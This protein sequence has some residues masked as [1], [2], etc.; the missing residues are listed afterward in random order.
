[1]KTMR[2]LL[3]SIRPHFRPL[4]A[5][6]G[7]VLLV[8][9]PSLLQ[10]GALGHPFSDMPDHYWGSWFF[11]EELLSGRW[12]IHSKIT[13][14]PEGGT[15]WIV[16]PVGGLLML[17]LRPLGFPGAWNTG[18]FLQ[19]LAACWAGYWFGWTQLKAQKPAFLVGLACGLSP[20]ALGI[21]HSGLSEYVG[22][23]WPPLFIGSLFLAYAKKEGGAWPGFLLF[24]ASLQALTFGLFGWLLALCF[25]PGPGFRSR[26]GVFFKLSGVWAALTLPLAL[27]IRSTLNASDALIHKANA[28]AWNP[29]TLPVTDLMSWFRPGD[30]VFP[31]TPQMGNPGI[32]HVNSLGILLLCLAI[33]GWLRANSLRPLRWG[34]GLF[35]ALSLG[36]RFSWGGQVTG[37]LLPMGLLYFLPF[38][39]FDSIHHPYRMAAFLTPL[40]ALWA[41][42]GLASL[43]DKLQLLLPGLLLAEWLF[44]SP[45]PWPIAHT[46]LP[47]TSQHQ[48]APK[49]A[50]LDFPPD[51]TQGNRTYLMGQVAH[52]RP[53][54]FGINRFLSPELKSNDLVGKMLRCMEH[55]ERLARNRD[56]FP[57]EPVIV[58]LLP[59]G[60]SLHQLGFTSLVL[61][62]HALNSREYPCLLRLLQTSG[63]LK[64]ENPQHALWLTR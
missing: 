48:L 35:G 4:L 62:K 5:L 61:H 52:Q 38:S 64:S 3:T 2:M 29:E 31:P 45:A 16:D 28:P 10:G 24:L 26:L 51:F 7:L 58:P 47:D 37:I 22:L 34:S 33:L 1:M 20:F 43:S 30:W 21:L 53:I 41:A 23:C 17:A 27:F 6:F 60:P 12:P 42:A 39:V 59:D 8:L 18:L 56:I 57:K 11:G 9:M 14:L 25:L 49:G 36:P 13:H 15:L 32:L 54:A 19:I 63:H 55:P 44:L 40:V 46:P 50:I